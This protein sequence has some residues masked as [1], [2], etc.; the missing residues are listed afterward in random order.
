VTKPLPEETG[1]PPFAR[2]SAGGLRIEVKVVP[3]ARRPGIAGPLGGRLKV[4]VAEL[5]E[6]G[7]ANAAVERL[8][9]AWLGAAEARVVAGHG[10]PQK[11]VEVRGVS[12]IPPALLVAREKGK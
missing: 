12:A 5:P 2:P 10:R 1:L 4:R 11:T 8:I 7:R 9:A 6:G 3:G